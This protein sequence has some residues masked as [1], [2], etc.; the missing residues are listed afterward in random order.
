MNILPL[1]VISAAIVAF[2][3]DE[4]ARFFGKLF[5]HAWVRLFLPLVLVSAGVEA[6]TSMYWVL[7]IMQSRIH[8]MMLSL[9]QLFPYA[10]WSAI[11]SQWLFL[12]LISGAPAWGLFW[13]LKRK[14][15]ENIVLKTMYTYLLVWLF[16][17]LLWVV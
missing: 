3:Q 12:F 6:W 13:W 17:I 10:T 4:F 1:L 16:L 15:A 5:S 7:A 9:F 2:F 14:D 8:A 11:F